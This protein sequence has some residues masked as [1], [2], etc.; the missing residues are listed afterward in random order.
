MNANRHIHVKE[1]F[2]QKGEGK[3]SYRPFPHDVTLCIWRTALR[4]ITEMGLLTENNVS[5]RHFILFPFIL[6]MLTFQSH[7]RDL[8]FCSPPTPPPPPTLIIN[9]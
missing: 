1:T 5:Y 9:G 4:I 3:T 7:T 6:H 2:L 8:N